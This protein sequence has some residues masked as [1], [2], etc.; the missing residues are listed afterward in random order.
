MKTLNQLAED[1]HFS[2]YKIIQAVSD[3]GIEPDIQLRKSIRVQV[4]TDDQARC[5]AEHMNR[6]EVSKTSI[7][8]DETVSSAPSL[9][10][11][12][13]KAKAQV[14][15]LRDERDYLRKALTE[16]QEATKTMA[17]QLA[18]QDQRTATIIAALSQPPKELTDTADQKRGFWQRVFG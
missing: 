8:P 14:E 17:E 9:L 13:A 10:E 11:E 1:L 5:I 15:L 16:S 3:L 6:K 4:F 7:K 2:R 12:L 18:T